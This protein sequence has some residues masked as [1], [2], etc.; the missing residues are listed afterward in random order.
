MNTAQWRQVE[1]QLPYGTKIIRSYSAFEN[2]ETRIIVK[3]PGEPYETR[4]IAHIDGETV[5]LEHRP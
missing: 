3:L 2:G 1:D 5:R 4:Y